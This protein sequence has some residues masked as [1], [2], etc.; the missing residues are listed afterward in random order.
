MIFNVE[1]WGQEVLF[2]LNFLLLGPS[3]REA[4]GIIM[5]R[6]LVPKVHKYTFLFIH[7]LA[8][9][10]TTLQASSQYWTLL[11]FFFISFILFLFFQSLSKNKKIKLKITGGSLLVFSELFLRVMA[12]DDNIETNLWCCWWVGYNYV[13]ILNK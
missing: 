7:T 4:K 5:R 11:T 6:Q 3:T 8:S 9:K 12:R 1:V 2:V 10:T 13:C